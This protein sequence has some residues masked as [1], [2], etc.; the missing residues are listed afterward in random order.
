MIP[1]STIVPMA[2]AI[3][4]NDIILASTPNTFMAANAIN[5]ASGRVT[6]IKRLA[7]I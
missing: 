2:I 4:A 3:P 5:I 7:C 6:A 1:M